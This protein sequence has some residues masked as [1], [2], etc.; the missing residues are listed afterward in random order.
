VSD[1]T[2]GLS[3][4]GIKII[5]HTGRLIVRGKIR[6]PK[7]EHTTFEGHKM[8]KEDEYQKSVR[9]EY[10]LSWSIIINHYSFDYV[11][12]EGGDKTLKS[13]NFRNFQTS[14]TL[15]LT[16][17]RVIRHNIVHYR[18][19]S[20]YQISFK[21]EKLFTDRRTEIPAFIRP[22]RRSRFK[23]HFTLYKAQEGFW[24]SYERYTGTKNF[25]VFKTDGIIYR[26]L[27]FAVF[28]TPP[29]CQYRLDWAMFNVSSN[30]V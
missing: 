7:I 1:V 25:A 22:I 30:T 5:S 2:T 16:F 13:A 19:L 24:R 26:T 14:V 27:N 10:T 21:S 3:D 11:Y 23:M 6:L 18:P 15:S 28:N 29:R 17:D 4:T 9:L 8:P 12:T 20:T